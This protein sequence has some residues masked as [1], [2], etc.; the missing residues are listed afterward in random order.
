MRLAALVV[1]SGSL[2]LLSACGHGSIDRKH[3]AML[4][5][6]DAHASAQMVYVRC[7]NGA[8]I[9]PS[10]GSVLE[11][12]RG[13]AFRTKFRDRFCADKT[14]EACQTAFQ[15]MIDAE[16]QKRYSGADFGAVAR[17]CDANP[18]T[19]DD[20]LAYETLLAR[21]HNDGVQR[22]HA[23][24]ESEI[25]TSRRHAKAAADAQ[26]AAIVGGAVT[27]AAIAVDRPRCLSYPSALTGVW[28]VHCR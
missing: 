10:C 21:S 18:G 17:H 5:E 28:V 14:D 3:D 15:R 24:V 27:L 13:E 4:A 20:P 1:C 11:L 7:P 22:G 9:G 8:H 6:A 19:C 23:D 12:A 25:E 26:T 2:V 16:L